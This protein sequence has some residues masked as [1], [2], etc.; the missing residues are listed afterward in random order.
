VHLYGHPSDMDP[1]LAI[2]ESNGLFVVEDAAEAHGARY[3]DRPV[4]SLGRVGIF[5][6][7]GNKVITTGEGGMVVSN[8]DALAAHIRQLRGQ[9]VDPERRY[10]FP[11]IGFNYRMTNVAAAIGLAQLE[12]IDWHIARRREV[13]EQYR[14]QLGG[15]AGLRLSPELSW[16]RSAFWMN[17]AVLPDEVERDTVM[18][19]LAAAGVETRPFFYPV[20]TLPPYAE[21]QPGPFPVAEQ[22]ATHG[23][24]LPSGATLTAEDV[25]YVSNALLAS[26]G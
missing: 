23:I 16:A 20:H 26:L 2:A 8:D 18:A 5:S 9:G 15:H 11:V 25:E 6:F 22:L 3:R 4:G 7:Y 1:L 10:W 21:L 19:R 17:C 13:A 14:H 24:N 12:R